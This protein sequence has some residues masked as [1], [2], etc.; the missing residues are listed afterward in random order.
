M[1]LKEIEKIIDKADFCLYEAV[2]E[3]KVMSIELPSSKAILGR[4]IE[5]DIK[6]GCEF[7]FY[8]FNEKTYKMTLLAKVDHIDREEEVVKKKLDEMTEE[9]IEELRNNFC[10]KNR[11]CLYC[12]LTSENGCLGLFAV[13]KKQ[14]TDNKDKE[15][16]IEIKRQKEK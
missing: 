11:T 6:Q 10:K 8:R 15:F 2:E 7:V 1:T 4:A 13:W 14:Y 3:R 5:H 12:P 16:E 9:E